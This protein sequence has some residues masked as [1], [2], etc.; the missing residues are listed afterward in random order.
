MVMERDIEVLEFISQFGLVRTDQVDRLA[1]NQIQVTNRRLKKFVDDKLLKRTKDVYGG[2]Y[3]YYDRNRIS[4]KQYRHYMIRNEL[5]LKL[6]DE[7]CTITS[8]IVDKQIG[9]I[10]PDAILEYTTSTGEYHFIF[11]EVELRCEKA[12]TAKYNKFFQSE[13]LEYCHTMPKVVY[14]TEKR[15]TGALFDFVVIDTKLNSISKI[16]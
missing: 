14:V 11:V 1:Y 16:L 6:L 5:Y 12:D 4:L 10:R 13:Y 8:V 7:G 3:L 2:G 9:S 15:I